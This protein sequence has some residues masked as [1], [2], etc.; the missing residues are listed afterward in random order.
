M[1]TDLIKPTLLLNS[2]SAHSKGQSQGNAN[3]DCDYP[4]N[5]GKNAQILLFSTRRKS[6]NGF[7]MVH[8]HLTFTHSI[9]QGQGR[10]NFHNEYLTNGERCE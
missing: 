3:C 1:V 6:L 8:L 2:T 4:V 5:G 7:R 10:V 9:H